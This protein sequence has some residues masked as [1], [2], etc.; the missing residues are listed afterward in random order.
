MDPQTMKA[1]T[2]VKN[3][4]P[5]EAFELRDIPVPEPTA[6]QVL[7]KVEGFGLNYADVMARLGFYPEA[8]PLPSVLGY[9]VVGY[10]EK[11]GDDVKRFSV[12]QRV[13][14]FTRFGGYAE[15]AVAE[16]EGTVAISDEIELGKALALGT[17]YCTAYFCAEEQVRLQKGDHVLIHAAAGG[18]GTALVQLAKRRRC[19][20][21][22]TASTQKLEHLSSIG[23]DHPIDYRNIDF[24]K[25]VRELV[26]DRGLDVIF[27]PI[28]GDYTRKG[29]KLLGP[30]GRIV[31]FGIS[32]LSGATNIFSKL[33]VMLGFGLF[34]PL[35]FVSTS[36]SLIGVNMLP[37]GDDRPWVLQRVMESVME[38]YEVHRCEPIVAAE[39]PMEQ[40][41]E[42]HQFLESRNSVGKIAIRL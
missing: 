18:V 9:E 38:L 5:E 27:D 7:I 6:N 39:Y 42:A 17:Q 31:V 33:R 15:F 35:Q 14:S 30:G 16:Q 36:K 25:K 41:A 8:P 32:S 29:I 26:G 3:G 4:V 20:V 23:V 37:I 11:I 13:L 21:Y 1:A 2:L 10:V 34:H 22:G 40:I 28:G 24:A 12:G 19:V